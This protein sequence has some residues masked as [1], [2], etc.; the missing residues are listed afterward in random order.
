MK[1][2]LDSSSTGVSRLLHSCRPTFISVGTV[3]IV[4]GL[5]T[6]LTGCSPQATTSPASVD[7]GPPDEATVHDD[8]V[9]MVIDGREIT[10]A[11]IDEHMRDQFMTEFRRQPADKQYTLRETAAKGLVQKMIVEGEAK[12]RGM[13]ADELL[14]QISDSAGTPTDDEIETWYKA[15]PNR[16]RG[17]Q[18]EDLASQIEQLLLSER[19]ITALKE[20]VDPI[21]EKT[22]WRMVLAPPRTDLD[23]TRLVRGAADAP[24]T[25]MTFSDYQCPYCIFAE[26]VLDEVL[27]RYPDKVRVAHR[28]FPLE[29]IHAFARP[30]AEA[31][32]CAE[33]QGKFWE[34]HQAIFN[35]SGKL[36]KDSLA[37]IGSDLGLDIEELNACIDER[38]FKEFVDTDFAAGR[39]AGVTGT[40][41]FFINGVAYNGSRDANG[42][43]KQIDLELA[44]IEG[45]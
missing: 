5:W 41:S 15:N 42:M 4:I 20:I 8:D 27:K 43:S 34:Y 39:A 24:I 30:A 26:P 31:S 3:A 2:I 44:R 32:M 22:S 37:K 19:R 38:R 28:H 13:S 12:K 25:I 36:S 35:L 29:S 45:R 18:L 7:A 16:A 40:P 11:E 10:V 21:L 9:A 1:T 23:T 17:A 6:L 14:E 33:A